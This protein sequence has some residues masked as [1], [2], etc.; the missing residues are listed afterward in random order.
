M[1]GGSMKRILVATAIAL[2]ILAFTATAALAQGRHA[3][4]DLGCCE[5]GC[6]E[7]CAQGMGGGRGNFE[8]YRPERGHRYE[9]KDPAAKTSNPAIPETISGSVIDAYQTTSIGGQGSGLHM[10]LNTDGE[11]LDVHLG[12]E[13]WL[14]EQN[15]SIEPGDSLEIKGHRFTKDGTP[16]MIAFELKQGD[17]LLALRDEDGFPLWRHSPKM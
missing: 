8:G 2:L 11:M 6:A 13:W 3:V 12:P 10:L 16:A 17:K 9:V 15:F 7:E 5:Q 4:H 14:D 1:E